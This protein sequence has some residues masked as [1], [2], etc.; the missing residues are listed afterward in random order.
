MAVT[1]LCPSCTISGVQTRGLS[2]SCGIVQPSLIDAHFR[3]AWI[4]YFRREGHPLVTPQAF[5]TFVWD[6]LPQAAVS[7]MLILTGDA[8]CGA[9]MLKKP[10][11]GRLDGWV[12]NETKALSLSC[13]VGLT[14]VLRQVESD[15]YI[16]RSLR[17]RL[18]HLLGSGLRLMPQ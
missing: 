6:H 4:L 3:K 10:T 9:A 1:E 5:L 8:L 15:A 17:L 14:Q 18:A 7:D 16:A 13:F 2:Q 12:W 11:A